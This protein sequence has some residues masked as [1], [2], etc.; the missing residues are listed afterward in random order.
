M[1]KPEPNADLAASDS[2][3]FALP[4]ETTAVSAW[5]EVEPGRYMPRRVRGSCQ[6]RAL[7]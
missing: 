4:D 7:G 2:P 6:G 5:E 3:H 1:N